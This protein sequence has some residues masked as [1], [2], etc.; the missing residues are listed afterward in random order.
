[1]DGKKEIVGLSVR[2][3]GRERTRMTHIAEGRCVK[4]DIGCKIE[5]ARMKNIAEKEGVS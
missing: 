1:M 3:E 2:G 5:Q 4:R